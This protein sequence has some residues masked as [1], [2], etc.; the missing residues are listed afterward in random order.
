MK[1]I[2]S[3]LLAMLISLSLFCACTNKTESETPQTP[4]NENTQQDTLNPD[5]SNDGD[6][7]TPQKKYNYLNDRGEGYVK[8]TLRVTH[9][10]G[11][12][13]DILLDTKEDNLGDALLEFKLIEGEESQYGL[14]VTT[15]DG[16][17]ADYNTDGAWWCFYKDGEMLNVGVSQT[18]IEEGAVYEAVYTKG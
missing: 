11:S 6:A 14:F 7:S 12:K 15:V 1:K 18:P 5:N 16:E 4:D 13:V 8:Y 9:S 3:L 10:D 17:S 2:T